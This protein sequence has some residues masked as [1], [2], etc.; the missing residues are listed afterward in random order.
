MATN[1]ALWRTQDTSNNAHD[2]DGDLA[3]LPKPSAKCGL[4][5]KQ[6]GGAR[7]L[8]NGPTACCDPHTSCVKLNYYYSRCMAPADA[9]V[10]LA[11][12]NANLA[13]QQKVTSYRKTNIL[14]TPK[15]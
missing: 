6:C 4:R 13:E 3:L 8:Y 5:N 11:N 2:G 9:A 1:R 14:P 12:S 10:A 15:S 7:G